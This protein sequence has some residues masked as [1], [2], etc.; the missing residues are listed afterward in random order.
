[1]HSEKARQRLCFSGIF[2]EEKTKMGF[3]PL[4]KI[5]ACLNFVFEVYFVEIFKH[6]KANFAGVAGRYLEKFN[7]IALENLQNKSKR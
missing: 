1:M 7:D 5:R 3:C 2:A 4:L 6:N